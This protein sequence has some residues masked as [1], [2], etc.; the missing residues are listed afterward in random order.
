MALSNG[1]KSKS[2]KS[3]MMVSCAMA[4]TSTALY[5]G[6]G[7]S[8]ARFD[9]DVARAHEIKPHRRTVPLK[10]M[11]E[12]SSQFHITLTVSP[13]GD[14]IDAHADSQE[15]AVKFWP[16]L[17]P[18]VRKWKFIPFENEGKPA[19]AEVEE[20]IDVVPP[21][22]LPTV[23]VP[24]PTLRADSKVTITLER[25]GCYGTCPAYIVSVSTDGIKFFGRHF[26][27]AAGNHIGTID[28][29][30][31]R[32]IA[33]RFIAANFYSMDASYRA[34]V[35]DNPTYA[36]TLSIDGHKKEVEDYVGSWVGMPEVITDLEDEV[37]A[38]AET[39]RWIEGANGL[40]SALKN[41]RFDFSTY[42]AQDIL[43][44]AASRGQTSTVQELLKAGTPL[45]P[46]PKPKVDDWTLSRW[47]NESGWLTAASRH[48]ETLKALLD[49]GASQTDQDDKNRA[50]AAAA[51]SG[52]L[53]AVQDLIA[54]GADPNANVTTDNG[55]ERTQNDRNQMNGPGTILIDAATSGNPDVV[56]EILRYHP[57]LEGRGFRQRTAIFSAGEPLTTDNPVDRVQC[58]RLLVQAGAN[59]NARDFDGDTPLHQIYL[60]DVEEELLKL[61]ADVNAR[62]NDGATPIFTNVDNDSVALFIAHGADL[63]VRNKKGKSV[64]QAAKEGGPLRQEALRKAV[65]ELKKK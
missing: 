38:I 1:L 65:Q 29:G 16:Q 40:T 13:T 9:Y 58:V 23:H 3:I 28:A 50:L 20:Y 33:N 41:E 42:Q 48:P 10:G 56:R 35:T 61:G 11:R 47:I 27:V 46:L 7:P 17:E 6:S 34:G 59:I 2:T 19:T 62:N 43:K 52:S 31:V 25:T 14:V 49:V 12:G 54:Y 36:L 4:L 51:R 21:E 24:S 53:K 55:A 22:R 39:G 37:D 15:N 8:F 5:S 18:E 57:D 45:A 44:Q 26:V 60:F 32:D 63:T 64:F 30:R